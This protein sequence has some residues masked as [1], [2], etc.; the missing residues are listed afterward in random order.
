MYTAINAKTKLDKRSVI[1]DL[2]ME[3]FAHMTVVKNPVTRPEITPFLD[4]LSHHNVMTK[5]GPNAE[6]KPLHA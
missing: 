5:T 6:P 4:V 2:K 1:T 3:I